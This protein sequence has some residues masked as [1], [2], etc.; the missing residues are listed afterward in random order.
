M[1]KFNLDTE[2]PNFG[3]SE[4]LQ[5]VNSPKYLEEEKN[6]SAELIEKIDFNSPESVKNFLKEFTKAFNDI[7]NDSHIVQMFCSEV[8]YEFLKNRNNLNFL[9]DP[10]T[11]ELFEKM[12]ETQDS[13]QNKKNIV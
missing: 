6:L 9:D 5:I 3:I 2:K 13:L 7:H 4:I 12:L 1:E 8:I 10:E 11:K